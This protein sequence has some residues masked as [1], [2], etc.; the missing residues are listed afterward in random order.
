[1]FF[2]F[3]RE[4]DAEIMRDRI[5]A[6]VLSQIHGIEFDLESIRLTKAAIQRATQ[7]NRP[8]KEVRFQKKKICVSKISK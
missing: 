2:Y 8:D 6:E 5:I 7:R 3:N 1:L 4:D